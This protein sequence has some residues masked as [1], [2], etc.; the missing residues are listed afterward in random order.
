MVKECWCHHYPEVWPWL[1]DP[2]PEGA[3]V[4]VLLQLGPAGGCS[5]WDLP[6]WV[7]VMVGMEPVPRSVLRADAEQH[8]DR[9]SQDTQDI[10]CPAAVGTEAQNKL[11]PRS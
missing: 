9:D 8:K 2:I 5:I 7:L 1:C 11:F 6:T 10:S 4:L 3:V